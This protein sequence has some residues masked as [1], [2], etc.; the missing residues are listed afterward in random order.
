MRFISFSAIRLRKEY[1]A[2]IDNHAQPVARGPL[3]A[4]PIAAVSIALA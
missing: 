4:G 3:S 2:K 1:L